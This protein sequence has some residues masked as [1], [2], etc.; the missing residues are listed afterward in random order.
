MTITRDPIREM[1]KLAGIEE[2]FQDI[3]KDLI[4]HSKQEVVSNRSSLEEL[5]PYIVI[6]SKRMSARAIS[7]WFEQTKNL[8]IS[9]AS[10]AKAIREKDRYCDLIFKRAQTGAR[11]LATVTDF[12]EEE[13]LLNIEHVRGTV[14]SDYHE[15][16]RGDDTS[17]QLAEEM[18]TRM[19]KLD[20]WIGLPEEIRNLCIK[21]CMRT[22]TKGEDGK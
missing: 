19:N 17:K 15:K 22:K 3:G 13:I 9:A 6:A 18:I 14:L 21:K 7:R 20:E 16:W 11:A 10:V 12:S 5:F 2:T 1:R 4:D 8:K